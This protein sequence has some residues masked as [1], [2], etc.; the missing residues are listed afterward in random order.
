MVVVLKRFQMDDVP[1]A[2]YESCSLERVADIYRAEAT[3]LSEKADS[4]DARFA[5]QVDQGIAQ[6]DIGTQCI[7]FLLVEFDAMNK[8][9]RSEVIAID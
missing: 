5:T 8:P 6:V 2:L 7:A 9:A 4:D 1:I 3:M